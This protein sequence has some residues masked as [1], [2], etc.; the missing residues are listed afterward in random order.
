[1]SVP[2]TGTNTPRPYGVAIN[3]A[4]TVLAVTDAANN[5]A[6]V[7]PSVNGASL[8]QPG[9]V[10]VGKVPDGVAVDGGNVFVANEGSGTVSVLD[11]PAHPT[12]KLTPRARLHSSEADDQP[13]SHTPLIAPL[14]GGWP[15]PPRRP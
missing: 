13:V 10:S 4:G 9:V 12:T 3:A 11:P 1:V 5:D 7:Y 15:K 6:V 8:G 14:P 2:T